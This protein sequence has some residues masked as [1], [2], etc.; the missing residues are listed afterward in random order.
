MSDLN[1]TVQAPKQPPAGVK[2][3][4]GAVDAQRKRPAPEAL[5]QKREAIHKATHAQHAAEQEQA[6]MPPP[7]KPRENIESLEIKLPDGRVVVFGPP[8]GV[9]LQMRI[10]NLLGPDLNNFTAMMAR[11]MMSVR[12]IE[13]Q[14]PGAIGNMVDVQRV[15][16]MLGE[17]AVDLLMLALNQY[18]PPVT[19][20]ELQIVKKNLR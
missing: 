1:I 3:M 10:A 11:A 4:Q 16:N 20:A 8:A 19:V 6:D 9:A 7:A 2:D 12:T 13:G 14:P 15:A 18:W 17:D 5:A